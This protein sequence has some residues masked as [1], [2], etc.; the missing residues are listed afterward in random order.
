MHFTRAKIINIPYYIFRSVEKMA[1]VSQ[2]REPKDEMKILF[3]HALIKIIVLYHLKELKIAWITSFPTPFSLTLQLR[4]FKTFHHHH[5]HP[6]LHYHVHMHLFLHVTGKMIVAKK[7]KVIRVKAASPEGLVQVR[8]CILIR[9]D[10]D[11]CFPTYCGRAPSFIISKESTQREG[12][13]R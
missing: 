12:K 5:I 13:G 8:W 6:H 9:A 11:K 7:I 4:M 1:Y 3:H 2:K 10:I